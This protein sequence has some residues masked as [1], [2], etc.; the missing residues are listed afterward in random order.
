MR[1]SSYGINTNKQRTRRDV[2]SDSQ[3][4]TGRYT[5]D[6]EDEVIKQVVRQDEDNSDHSSD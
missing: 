2:G 6:F 1:S 5:D 4:N 3:I